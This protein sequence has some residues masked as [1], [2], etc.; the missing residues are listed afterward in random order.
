MCGVAIINSADNELFRIPSKI[1][2][3][4]GVLR[5][6]IAL[7]LSPKIKDYN[8]LRAGAERRNAELEYLSVA[9]AL[10]VQI[11]QGKRFMIPINSKKCLEH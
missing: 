7:D 8:S 4:K 3:N 1:K 6:I 9:K 11:N 5:T 10:V 2:N